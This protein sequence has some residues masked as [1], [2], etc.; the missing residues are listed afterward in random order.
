MLQAFLLLSFGIIMSRD[1]YPSRQQTE[2]ED[3]YINRC[4]LWVIRQSMMTPEQK[5]KQRRE[6]ERERAL[7]DLPYV[8]D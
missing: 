4:A 7:R 3:D 2:S 1:P 6:E 8:I 5:E